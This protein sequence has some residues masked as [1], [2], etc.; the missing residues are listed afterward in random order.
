MLVVDKEAKIRSLFVMPSAKISGERDGASIKLHVVAF[1]FKEDH[2]V[3]HGWDGSLLSI[4]K[5]FTFL[6]I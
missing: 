6:C 1:P 2:R 3:G 5:I 4:L